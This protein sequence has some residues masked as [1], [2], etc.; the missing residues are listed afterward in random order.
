MERRNFVKTSAILGAAAAL[1]RYSLAAARGSDRIK[2]GIIG[3]GNRGCGAFINMMEADQNIK[4][5]AMA[6]L[7]EDK[8][9]R[10]RKR[11]IEA[12]KK[13]ENG[14]EIAAEGKIKRFIGVGC[15]D[16]LL[17]EDVDV[18]IDACSPV[19]RT[20]HFEK[21]VAAGKHA[22]LEKP[23]CVDAVQARKML[24]LSKKADEKGLCVVCGTQRRYDVGYQEAIER[25]RNGEIGEIVSAQCYWN[26]SIY[27]GGPKFL[28][29]EELACDTMEYQIRNW[30]SFIWASGDNIVE[31]HVHNLDVAMWA[32]GDNRKPVEVRAWGGR[33]TDLPMPK[34]GDRFSHFAVDFDMGNGLRL[35]SYCQQDP[36]AA[37]EVGERIIGTNGIMYSNLYGQISISERNG[38]KRWVFDKSQRKR[39]SMV[40]EHAFLL[41][42][43]R[44]GKH[45]NKID[46][47]VNSTLLAIA[48]RMSAYSG[49]K[50]KFD[51]VLKKSQE[52]FEPEKIELAKKMPMNG[53]PV[54]GKYKLV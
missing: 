16:Q 23:P 34:F 32:L 3:C 19:F 25:I 38:K 4:L 14:A 51:W 27:V 33:S 31:Q 17:A 47:L 11:I 50:F 28:N 43:I 24:E 20:P 7:F 41:D 22:F 35:A 42:A 45:V 54:P 9:E 49:M 53:V 26:A 44:K 30:F 36:K 29:H 10:G 5:V 40:E 52:S 13:Y 6:D 2:V 39:D 21:I 8:L 15:E 18:V 48:G 46:Q 1:P 12:A 37:P